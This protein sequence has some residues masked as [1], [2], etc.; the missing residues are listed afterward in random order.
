MRTIEMEVTV[1]KFKVGDKVKVTGKGNKGGW[2]DKMKD[3]IGKTG[4]V[5]DVDYA[6]SSAP[7]LRVLFSD[8][9]WWWY[10]PENLELVEEAGQEEQLYIC[11]YPPYLYGQGGTPEEAYKNLQDLHYE[12]VSL[13][14]CKFYKAVPIE[15]KMK[16]EVQD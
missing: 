9:N 12:S 5:Y 10:Y 1:H 13:L 4:T 2:V 3:Y 14:N 15:V 11:S 7:S 16:L 6:P 8:N